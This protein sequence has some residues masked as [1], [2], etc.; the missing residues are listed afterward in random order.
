MSVL[1]CL[2]C[3]II[4]GYLYD[5]FR[6]IRITSNYN[7]FLTLI[8][9]LFFWILTGTLTILTFFFID[10]LNLRFYRF[11]AIIAGTFLYFIFFSSFF[12]GIT[13]KILKIFVY[14]FKILFTI[15]KFC[16][17]ILN[18]VWNTLLYPFRLLWKILAK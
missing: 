13:E 5:F 3:G 14:F 1:I 8:A 9:D 7:K 18:I 6:A 15:T 11:L 17:R 10:G 4:T 2:I 16:G 12:L